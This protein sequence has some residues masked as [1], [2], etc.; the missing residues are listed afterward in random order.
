MTY[1]LELDVSRPTVAFV[2][3]V[4]WFTAVPFLKTRITYKYIFVSPEKLLFTKVVKYYTVGLVKVNF[5]WQ[6]KDSNDG[7]E[8]CILHARLFQSRG[9][10]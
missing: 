5:K 8:L 1:S 6:I 10:R 9:K 7:K 2:L 3:V 4:P